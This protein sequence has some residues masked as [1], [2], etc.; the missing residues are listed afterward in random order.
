MADPSMLRNL[1]AQA[2]VIWP[3]EA[4]LLARDALAAGARVLDLGCGS[5]E[6]TGRLAA[7]F[8]D[9]TILGVD[10]LESSLAYARRVHASLGERVRFERGDA[11]DLAYEDASFDLVVCRHVTQSVPEPERIVRAMARVMRPGGVMH[12][13]SEDYGML[14]IATRPGEPDANRL[15]REVL[16]ALSRATNID[17]R[18]GRRTWALLRDAG[19]VDVTVDFVVVDTVRSPR[20]TFAE[21]LRAWRDGYEAD[22]AEHA[23]LPRA[24]VRALFD[25]AIGAVLDEGYYS[26]W[27]VPVVR[28]RKPAL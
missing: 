8:P 11:F 1:A 9:A 13:L 23:R 15:W 28:G 24:E 4:P 14:H 3:G 10:L 2:A 12:V 18:V 26:V 20:E 16:P 17:E 22:L 21:I 6:I 25:A 27:H 5:G 7:L 19:L